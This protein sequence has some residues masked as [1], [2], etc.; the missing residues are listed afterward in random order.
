MTREFQSLVTRI[1]SA[2]WRL[3][4]GARRVAAGS[5]QRASP[6]PTSSSL[7]DNV[8]QAER[9]INQL[10][11]RDAAAPRSCRPSSTT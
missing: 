2:R 3:V 4:A 1:A 10:R 7:Q 8:Y 11:D 9:D 5:S 6:R